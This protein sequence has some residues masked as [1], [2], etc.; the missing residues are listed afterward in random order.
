[1]MNS[2]TSVIDST[3]E[4]LLGFRVPDLKSLWYG[5]Q[6]AVDSNSQPILR[7]FEVYLVKLQE[8]SL[9]TDPK[10]S[11]A[12]LF[13]IHL[14]YWYL[15]VTT[16]SSIYLV[17][18]IASISFL[19]TTWTQR[20]WP[21]IRIPQETKSS[22]SFTP[23]SPDVLSAPELE[24]LIND[25]KIKF[26]GFLESAKKLR[27]DEPGR[28]C[29]LASFVFLILA[30]IGSYITTLGLFYY[31]SVGYLTIPG[32]LKILVKHPAVQCML[33]TMENTKNE[34][35]TDNK[36]E[37]EP[38]APS[39]VDSVYS[40]LQ[41]GFQ[42][43][44]NLNLKSEFLKTNQGEQELSSLIP[45]ENEAN[46]SILESAMNCSTRDPTQAHN[47]EIEEVNIN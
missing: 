36:T 14:I 20:I 45:E 2:A 17:F 39:L 1:M 13:A 8:L 37:V 35:E 44:S 42:A 26:K 19:Y 5:N 11:M 29:G 10:S 30:F 3:K 4:F 33:E 22:E 9:W 32:V 43:V 21:E 15:A 12:A 31:V 27:R 23:L 34:D 25:L 6:D 7:Q 16:N 40:T 46:Q 38:A 41:S 47:L 28:F 24:K 18:S